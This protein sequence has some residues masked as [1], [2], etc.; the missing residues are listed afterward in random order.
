MSLI[1][2]RNRNI[3]KHQDAS[4]RADQAPVTI[5]LATIVNPVRKVIAG[6][7]RLIVLLAQAYAEAR[8]HQ[9]KL[10]VELYR[11]RFKLSSKNDDDLPIVR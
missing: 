5:S 6:V 7:G 2:Y 8:M 1:T 10:E 3:A 4:G 11:N 9:A